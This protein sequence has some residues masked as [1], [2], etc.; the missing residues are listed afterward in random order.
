MN[1]SGLRI[2]GEAM[3]NFQKLWVRIYK[4]EPKDWRRTL[5]KFLRNV[6]E[7]KRTPPLLP[8][9]PNSQTRYFDNSGWLFITSG[10]AANMPITL[11]A[12]ART[13]ETF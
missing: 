3:V 7:I 9:V 11:R 8:L 12:V 13:K 5:E 1:L 6:K 10:E 2:S 4:S